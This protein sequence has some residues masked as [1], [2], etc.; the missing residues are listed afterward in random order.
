[1]SFKAAMP[2]IPWYIPINSMCGLSIQTYIV[3]GCLAEVTPET[4][5]NHY[6]QQEVQHDMYN[7]C[8]QEAAVI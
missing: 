7:A 4:S 5:N 3:Q 2:Y 6:Y 1:M 8:C